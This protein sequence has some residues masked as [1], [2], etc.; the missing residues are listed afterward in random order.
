MGAENPLNHT[1][2]QHIHAKAAAINLSASSAGLVNR[3]SW[4]PSISM[5]SNV[6]SREDICGWKHPDGSDLS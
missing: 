6:P 5:N 3:T 2:D 4:L 1:L